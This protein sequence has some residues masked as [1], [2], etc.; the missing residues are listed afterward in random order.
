MVCLQCGSGSDD[1][2]GGVVTPCCF[3][4]VIAWRYVVWG[5]S[6]WVS[7]FDFVLVAALWGWCFW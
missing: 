5:D 2:V 4:G 1:C 7:S 6:F 3:G